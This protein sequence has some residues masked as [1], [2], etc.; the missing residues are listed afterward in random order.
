MRGC[1]IANDGFGEVYYGVIEE[2]AASI[3]RG[4]VFHNA[5]YDIHR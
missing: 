4:I 1:V 2:S 3:F 5:V